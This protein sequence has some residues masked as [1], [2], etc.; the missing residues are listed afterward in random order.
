MRLL[1]LPGALAILAGCASDRVVSV[2]GGP[3]RT[4]SLAVG[5]DLALT[6]HTLGPG[7]YASPPSI[8]GASLRFLADSVVPP[9]T[10][11]GPTQRFWFRGEAPG[12]AVVTFHHTWQQTV[13][14][15]TVEVR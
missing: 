3:S 12:R 11:G 2:E 13:V 14:E 6:L 9:F 1:L 4:L 8:S 15:D 7:Q 5:Q 10:P